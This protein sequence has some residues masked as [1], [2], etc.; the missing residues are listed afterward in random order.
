[1]QLNGQVRDK[2][3]AD[4]FGRMNAERAAAEAGRNTDMRIRGEAKGR[5]RKERPDGFAAGPNRWR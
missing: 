4:I 2:V 3:E 5:D 1:V